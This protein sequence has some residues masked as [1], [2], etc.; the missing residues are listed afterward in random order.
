LKETRTERPGKGKRNGDRSDL[1]DEEDPDHISAGASRSNG[2]KGSAH[3]SAS[4]LNM[5]SSFKNKVSTATTLLGGPNHQ[6]LQ[7]GVIRDARNNK[8]SKSV[9]GVGRARTRQPN[10]HMRS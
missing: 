1:L 2:M 5:T 8:P 10:Q 7:K 6:L 3:K 9:S 4:Y